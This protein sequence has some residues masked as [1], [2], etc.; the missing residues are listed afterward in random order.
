MAR[1]HNLKMIG[2]N[3][4]AHDFPGYEKLAGR[5][6]NAGLYFGAL[7]ENVASGDTFVMRVYHEQLLAS[8]GHRENLLNDR[9]QQLGIGVARSGEQYYI[10]QEFA[11]L[12]TPVPAAEMERDMEDDLKARLGR[13]MLP[14]RTAAQL[15]ENSRQLAGLFL[16]E[17]SPPEIADAMGVASVH[18]FSFIDKEDGF[19]RL[20]AVIKGSR[21]L[22]WALGVTFARSDANPGGIYALTLIVFPD[23]RDELQLYGGLETVIQ[24]KIQK[25]RAMALDPNLDAAAAQISMQF[26]ESTASPDSIRIKDCCKL[27]LAYQSLSLAEIPEDIA[28]KIAVTPKISSVGIH[29]FYPLLEGLLGNY[30]IVAIV[31]D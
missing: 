25:I 28:Q 27:I 20:L 9:F 26:Y 6:V 4:L 16:N 11:S 24:K 7:G 19:A 21:P 30:F 12:F 15:K 1:A 2:E 13:Q 18:N 29:V 17:Q 3:N 5:A 22:Y 23:L 31:A 10:T 14:S 8:P